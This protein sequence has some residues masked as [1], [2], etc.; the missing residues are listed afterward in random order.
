MK[1]HILVYRETVC[2]I[3]MVKNALVK[4]AYCLLRHLQSCISCLDILRRQ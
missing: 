3:L 2:D 1:L 4:S